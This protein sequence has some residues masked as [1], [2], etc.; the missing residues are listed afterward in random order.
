VK[1]GKKV[2]KSAWTSGKYALMTKG[3]SLPKYPSSG[4]LDLVMTWFTVSL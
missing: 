4:K 1:N 3:G 2:K